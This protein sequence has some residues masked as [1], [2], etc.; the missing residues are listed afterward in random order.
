MCEPEMNGNHLP[1]CGQPDR[2]RSV[3]QMHLVLKNIGGFLIERVGATIDD[4]EVS[5]VLLFTDL[6][7][8]VRPH[9]G[10]NEI[11]AVP[12]SAG[13]QVDDAQKIFR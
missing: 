1:M 10:L 11:R 6:L 2:A 9:R 7:R 8:Y 13:S 12:E 4:S 5:R 3:S